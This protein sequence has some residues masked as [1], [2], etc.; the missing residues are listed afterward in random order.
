MALAIAG[1]TPH[2]AVSPTPLAPKGPLRCS[3]TTASLTI[4]SGRSSSPGILYSASD[5][6]L[7]CPSASNS[8]FS[9]RVKPSCMMAPPESCVSTMRGLLGVPTSATFTIF[10]TRTRPV[11]VS[12]SIST[13]VAPTI[14]NGVAF[15]VWPFSSGGVYGG[16]KLPAPIT[17]PARMPYFFL[18]TSATGQS[19]GRL[20]SCLNCSSWR[21]ASSA[22]SF[23]ALPL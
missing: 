22:A 13:P 18:N 10:V 1:D 23:T 14:Q 12:T 5:A 17:D 11:S 16:M 15:S 7:S 3:A 2:V 4:S 19:A 8:I 6:F 21:F 20:S 9:N